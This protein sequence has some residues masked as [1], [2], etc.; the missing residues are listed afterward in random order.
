MREQQSQAYYYRVKR[1]DIIKMVA[2]GAPPLAIIK[3]AVAHD[4][5]VESGLSVA[6][7]CDVL[8][9]IDYKARLRLWAA[10]CAARAVHFLKGDHTRHRVAVEAIIS[11]RAFARSQIN[12]DLVQRYAPHRGSK[13][14]E[15]F[16]LSGDLAKAE[17]A[18]A[19]SCAADADPYFA[20]EHA[21]SY[22]RDAVKNAKYKSGSARIGD[23]G[24]AYDAELKWQIKRLV[25]Q[26]SEESIPDVEI[27]MADLIKV[28]A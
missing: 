11:A 15:D 22:A 9:P 21:A 2:D 27:Q 7:G 3:A 26:M 24:R 18:F 8:A 19:A 23:A 6:T 13:L 20:A 5:D 12:Y 17:A 1:S 16:A 14:Y 28:S 25:A 10:D 4:C